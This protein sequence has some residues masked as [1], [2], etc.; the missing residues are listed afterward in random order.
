MNN[1]TKETTPPDTKIV[2]NDIPAGYNKAVLKMKNGE[3]I[4]LDSAQGSLVNND[5]FAVSNKDGKLNYQSKTGVADYHT[6]STPRGG[7]Y[8]LQ[9]P[10]GTIVWLNA[11]SSITYPTTFIGQKYRGV[12]VTGEAYFEVKK[13]KAQP[14]V[15][16]VKGKAAVEVLGTHFN[17]N[18]YDDEPV[19]NTTLLE[20]SIRMRNIGQEAVLTPGQQAQISSKQMKI[21]DHADIEMAVAWKNGSF[22]F[23]HANI[24]EVLRQLARWYDIEIAY[25]KGVPG[26]KVSG[27]IKRDLNLTQ[28]L[29]IL[30]K[31][32]VHARIEGKQLLV[33]P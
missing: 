26:V 14:F 2:A 32:G 17:V 25:E 9:L 29:F 19:I 10:D 5:Q 28:A 30:D 24:E 13:N 4:N 22:H 33:T 16:D 21:I 23:D 15:V 11:A 20:G 31:M 8:R 7:Q 3:Q 6:L 12:T 1:D 27:E 18:A